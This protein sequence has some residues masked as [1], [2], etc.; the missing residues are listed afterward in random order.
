[1]DIT[2][3]LILRMNNARQSTSPKPATPAAAPAA[4]PADAAK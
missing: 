2:E 4:A 1:V 3:K